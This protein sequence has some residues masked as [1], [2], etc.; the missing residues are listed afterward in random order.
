[1]RDRV[2]DIRSISQFMFVKKNILRQGKVEQETN[3]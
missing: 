3:R 2:A 1:M